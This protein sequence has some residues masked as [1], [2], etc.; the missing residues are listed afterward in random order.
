MQIKQIQ[1]ESLVPY[2]KNPRI[3]E[4]AVEKVQRSIERFGFNQPIV[5]NQDL[6]ICVGHTRWKAAQKAGLK[7]VPVYVRNMSESEFIA[8]N[9]ADNRTSEES[10]W[11]DELL[12]ELM[13]ELESLDSEL[14]SFTSFTDSEI[15]ALLDN[16]DLDE[17]VQDVSVAGGNTTPNERQKSHVKMVQ[18]FF[19]QENF[20]EFIE[21]CQKIQTHHGLANLTDTVAFVVD[22]HVNGIS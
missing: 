7:S 5:T 15:D 2:D 6:V 18:L 19:N 11:D 13:R 10:K 17:I 14:L 4:N 1:I 12:G 8:Y 21:A 22:E 16:D 3:N 9:I 20:P